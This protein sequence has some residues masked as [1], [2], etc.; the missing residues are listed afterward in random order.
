ME[1][2]WFERQQ[3]V[4]CVHGQDSRMNSTFFAIILKR[5]TKNQWLLWM[6][7]IMLVW[8][9]CGLDL[10]NI[11][12]VE[13]TWETLPEFCPRV[14]KRWQMMHG[15]YLST[16]GDQCL[17]LYPRFSNICLFILVG[18]QCSSEASGLVI[19]QRGWLLYL[20]KVVKH[21]PAVIFSGWFSKSL[22]NTGL[23]GARIVSTLD[24]RLSTVWLSEIDVN[25]FQQLY[26]LA[27]F[28]NRWRTLDMETQ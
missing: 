16:W 9:L 12:A 1:R 10:E 21:L 19:T 11:T 23:H 15:K 17:F 7:N 18:Y 28:S 8:L 22:E 2:V 6:G 14:L 4:C 24:S 5:C 25:L 20:D 26:F 27:G 3:S 13:M